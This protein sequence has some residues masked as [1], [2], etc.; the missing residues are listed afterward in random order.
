M[1]NQLT[2]SGAFKD[3]SILASG[4]AFNVT[5]LFYN[6]NQTVVHYNK[7]PL[8]SNLASNTDDALHS[9]FSPPV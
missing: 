6:I 4:I 7:A 5:F 1:L 3:G 2:Q 8:G 9:I